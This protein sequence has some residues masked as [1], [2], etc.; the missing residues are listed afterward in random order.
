MFHAIYRTYLCQK[1]K[2]VISDLTGCLVFY[3]E[4]SIRRH[5]LGFAP[6]TYCLFLNRHRAQALSLMLLHVIKSRLMIMITKVMSNVKGLFMS[7]HTVFDGTS[8]P[9]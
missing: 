1:K 9:S 4:I 7:S 6:H 3:L 5:T 8:D 2:F